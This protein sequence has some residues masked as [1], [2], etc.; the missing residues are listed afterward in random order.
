MS[1]ADG[2]PVFV[3][4]ILETKA[5]SVVLPAGR[6]VGRGVGLGACEVGKFVEL[7]VPTIYALFEV[8]AATPN[9]RRHAY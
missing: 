7:V 2:F 1:D 9:A 6:P 3:V 4:S 5:A 8:S